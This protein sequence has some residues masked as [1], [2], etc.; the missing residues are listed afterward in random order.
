MIHTKLKTR[1]A[2]PNDRQED[3]IQIFLKMTM[4]LVNKQLWIILAGAQTT[5]IA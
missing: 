4:D 5:N 3:G 1:K 2:Q